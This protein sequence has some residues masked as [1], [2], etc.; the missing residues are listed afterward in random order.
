MEEP[1]SKALE[2]VEP[3]EA[4]AAICRRLAEQDPASGPSDL[5]RELW[6]FAWVPV[7]GMLES[8][9]ALAAIEESVGIHRELTER[10]PEAVDPNLRGALGTRAAVLEAMGSGAETD[11]IRRDLDRPAVD[12]EPS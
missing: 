1:E 10:G 12:D 7:T 2:S 3:S 11:E 4:A 8:D 5:A 9:Q 6:F